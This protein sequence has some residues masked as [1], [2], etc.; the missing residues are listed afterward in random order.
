MPHFTGVHYKMDEKTGCWMVLS[1]KP[2]TAGYIYINRVFLKGYLHRIAYSK[3]I[4]PI[5]SYDRIRHTCK[6]K[7]CINPAHLYIL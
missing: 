3:H 7:T 1:N 6:N 4:K 2:N 5:T